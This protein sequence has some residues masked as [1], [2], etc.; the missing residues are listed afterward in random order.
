MNGSVRGRESYVTRR[1]VA[2]VCGAGW[3]PTFVGMTAERNDDDECDDSATQ[4]AEDFFELAS[5]LP[6]DLLR[7][8]QIL[9]CFL[10]L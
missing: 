7:L 1:I 6:H 9:A 8:R 4:D 2:S 10:A 3:I 5:Q